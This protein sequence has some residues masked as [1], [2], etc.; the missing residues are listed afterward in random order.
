MKWVYREQ[1]HADTKALLKVWVNLAE[2]P[3]SC[4]NPQNNRELQENKLYY[5][6]RKRKENPQPIR[7]SEYQKDK[8][9]IASKIRNKTGGN[10][11]N[12]CEGEGQGERKSGLGDRGQRGALSLR[13][14]TQNN[15]RRSQKCSLL[16]ADLALLVCSRRFAPGFWGERG[17]ARFQAATDTLS[18]KEGVLIQK[19]SC[20][21]TTPLSSHPQ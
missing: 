14:Q 21:Q 16:L 15:Q 1:N 20:R 11:A 19:K 8:E 4:P 6:V 10:Q 5:S 17:R 12:T 9:Q 3:F 13:P 18:G 2:D 7:R